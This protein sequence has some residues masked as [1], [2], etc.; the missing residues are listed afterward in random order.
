MHPIALGQTLPALDSSLSQ[1]DQSQNTNQNKNTW[2]SD[3]LASLDQKIFRWHD[4]T[5]YIMVYIENGAGFRSWDPYH[6][7]LVHQAFQAWENGLNENNVNGVRRIHFIYMPD[8]R[9][10][11]VTVRWVQRAEKQKE[12]TDVTGKNELVTWGKYIQRNDIAIAV[13]SSEGEPRS[14]AELQT[15]A[16]HEVG[17]MLG[18]RGH[19]P[20]PNDVMFPV[21][22]A[23]SM[24]TPKPLSQRD[25]NTIRLIYQK[26]ADYT[27]PDS[28]HLSHFEAFKKSHKGRGFS[29]MWISIS[30][31]PVPIPLPF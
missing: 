18:I 2:P 9:G 22:M 25:I 10:S 26:K 15:T 31:I 13:E 12:N 7:T 23:L 28:V 14:S 27:N 5:Q 20:D 3:Y 11:D 4:K 1:D 6:E 24:E 16:L 19:S 17:H 8:T 30:G 29:I 21:S